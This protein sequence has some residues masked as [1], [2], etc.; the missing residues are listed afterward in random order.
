MPYD[1]LMRWETEG[2]A[3]HPTG[4][5]EPPERPQ[6]EAVERLDLARPAPVRRTDSLR[7]PAVGP[8]LGR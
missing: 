5:G 6:E 4:G 8:E 7:L 1:P 3:S 2:G